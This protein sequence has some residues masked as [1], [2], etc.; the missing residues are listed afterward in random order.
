MKVLYFDPILGVSGDM[1]LASLI[2]LGISKDYLKKQLAFIPKFEI[3][4][5]RV[6]KNGVSARNIQFKIRTKIS[7]KEFIPL[8]NK[9]TLSSTIKSIA[10]K[11]I[12]RI[13]DVE[14]K[15]HRARQL[16]LHELADADTLLDIVGTLVAIDYLNVDKIYSKPMKA[17][18]GFIKTVEGNM[19]AFNFATAEL[20]KGYPVEFMPIPAELTTPTGAAIVSTIAEP[21][22]DLFLSKI[23]GIGLGAGTIDIKG[24]PNLLRVFTGEVPGT[25]GDECLVIE[26]N[27]DDMNPQDYDILFE[28]LYKAGA[29]EVSLS[30][31]IMKHSR[32]GTLL[33]VL[34]KSDDT[35]I[36]DMLFNETTTL[37]LRIHRMKRLTLERRIIKLPSPYGVI[38]VKIVE[39]GKKRRFSLEYQDLKKMA[40]KKNISIRRLRAELTRLVEKKSGALPL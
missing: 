39:Y 16:H 11:I 19:P 31:I 24:Y 21:K 29:L 17:G 12:H 23:D 15:V 5:S 38:R 37:G 18:K 13:F 32:P 20:L 33:T 28:R 30:P 35:K 14:K 6:S 40:L 26:T 3:V 9:S 8:I 34:C 4:V 2:D 36:A 10:T 1:I 22:D 27:I 25:P 7:E